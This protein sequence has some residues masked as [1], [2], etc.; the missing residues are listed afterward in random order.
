MRIVNMDERNLFGELC[1]KSLY[2]QY[3]KEISGEN[4]KCSASHYEKM[5]AILGYSVKRYRLHLSKRL[6]AAILAAVILLLAG[7]TV[8]IYREKIKNLFAEIHDRYVK[9]FSD[10]EE[11]STIP[12]SEIYSLGY[13]PEGYDCI[14]EKILPVFVSYKWK[15]EQGNIISFTQDMLKTNIFL[16]YEHGYSKITVIENIEM[17]YNNNGQFSHYIWS[18]GLYLMTLSFNAEIQEAELVD[19]IQG[20]KK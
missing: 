4:A 10:A 12:I 6:I 7:C 20:I 1:E 8:Y 5:S 18:D 17:Y 16:D 2:D 19:I 11:N 15:N 9:V 14:E 3:E 13:I